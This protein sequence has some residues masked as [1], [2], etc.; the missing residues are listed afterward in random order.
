MKISIVLVSQLKGKNL[1]NLIL[2]YKKRV[3]KFS[4]IDF[5]EY[6]KKTNLEQIKKE[7]KNNYIFALAEKGR[8]YTSLEFSEKID[9]ISTYTNSNLVF[10]ISDAD[11]FSED[12]IKFS[13]E[14]LSLGKM[15]FPHE[16]ATMLIFEQVYRALSILNNHPYHRE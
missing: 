16:I 3:S 15:T 8:E 1:E 14:I 2:E 7:F 11:G 6:K 13:D 9:K 5:I 4:Q 10:V 12:E